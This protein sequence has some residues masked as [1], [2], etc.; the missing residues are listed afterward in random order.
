M[1]YIRVAFKTIILIIFIC[2]LLCI[3]GAEVSQFLIITDSLNDNHIDLKFIIY[4]EDI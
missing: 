2:I 4:M 1:Y 3:Y